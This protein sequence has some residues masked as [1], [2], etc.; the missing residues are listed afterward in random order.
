MNA[1]DTQRRPWRQKMIRR[2][3][4][5]AKRQL[6]GGWDCLAPKVQ[7][8]VIR[9]EAL[10]VILANHR[11]QGVPLEEVQWLVDSMLEQA[12]LSDS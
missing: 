7:I 6:G 4:D 11:E 12:G 5:N 1:A 3:V 8:S 10:T 2:F 9:A